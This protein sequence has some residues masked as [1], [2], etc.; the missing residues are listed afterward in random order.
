MRRQ[1]IY[2]ELNKRLMVFHIT[3]DMK[4]SERM[5][6][7]RVVEERKNTENTSGNKL[8]SEISEINTERFHQ[9]DHAPITLIIN[10]QISR[11][12]QA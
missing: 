3:A 6:F 12:K 9:S 11:G 4:Y 2:V 8:K 10:I 1:F 5:S 7:K